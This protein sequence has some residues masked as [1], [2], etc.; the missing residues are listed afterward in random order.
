MKWQTRLLRRR[1][2]SPPATRQIDY[3]LH[4]LIE[5]LLRPGSREGRPGLQAPLLE[6]LERPRG[7]TGQ[8]REEG[9]IQQSQEPLRK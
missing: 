5:L 2:L 3:H 4:T 9:R 7:P 8:A 1:P 6:D